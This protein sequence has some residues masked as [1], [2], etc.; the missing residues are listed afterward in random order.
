MFIMSLF[1]L[2]LIELGIIIGIGDE[3]LPIHVTVPFF[4]FGLVPGPGST[5]SL[6]SKPDV[7]IQQEGDTLCQTPNDRKRSILV[8]YKQSYTLIM[9]HWTSFP[10]LLFRYSVFSV[11]STSLPDLTPLPDH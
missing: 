10:N 1:G 3:I 4:F 9:Q 5:S 6:P 2:L 11:E 8:S 7:P